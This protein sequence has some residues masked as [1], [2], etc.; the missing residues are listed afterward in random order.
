MLLCLG[1]LEV[2]VNVTMSLKSKWHCHSSLQNS[3]IFFFVDTVLPCDYN[4]FVQLLKCDDI[5]KSKITHTFLLLFGF[6]CVG[7]LVV[8]VYRYLKCIWRLPCNTLSAYQLCQRGIACSY[9]SLKGPVE[10]NL[11]DWRDTD[12]GQSENLKKL[13]TCLALPPQM[14]WH[15][16]WCE[17]VFC[18]A[19]YTIGQP[20]S[21]EELEWMQCYESELRIGLWAV[22]KL[23]I[24]F[25]LHFQQW[26]TQ[27]EEKGI[28]LISINVQ[29]IGA[30]TKTGVLF[31]FGQIESRN[32]FDFFF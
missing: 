30:K 14:D 11:S 1:V 21:S 3:V 5:L 15:A 4:L 31:R 18:I 27:I 24:G 2:F 9:V 12:S 7:A 19:G 23:V 16:L 32:S 20:D 26:D 29:N 25:N 17:K 10:V 6:I 8:N 22:G 28:Y 13:K